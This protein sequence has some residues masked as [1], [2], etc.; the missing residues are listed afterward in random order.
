[1]KLYDLERITRF[2]NA[3]GS[4]QEPDKEAMQAAAH[5]L[6]EAVFGGR[7]LNKYLGLSGKKPHSYTSSDTE[8]SV[9]LFLEL[10][11]IRYTEAVEQIRKI[12]PV[13]EKQA[14]KIIRRIRP[15]AKKTADFIRA[16]KASV[17]ASS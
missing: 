7:N 6:S 16:L 14:E 3:I 15:D 5:A 4:H 13:S 2:I 9:V 10:N 11:K 1:M 8:Y 12:C 17:P